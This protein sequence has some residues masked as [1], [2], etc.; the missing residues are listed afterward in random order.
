MRI[1]APIHT[2][3]TASSSE[4]QSRPYP[5]LEVGQKAPGFVLPDADM[6]I[7]NLIEQASQK[8]VVLHFY[9]R[10]RSPSGILQATDFSEHAAEFDALGCEAVAITPDD[11]PTHA[12]FRDEYGLSLRLLSDEDCDICRLYGAWGVRQNGE[13]VRAGVMR[14]T[15]I[16]DKRGIIREI[17]RNV[18]PRGHV[19]EVLRILQE[20]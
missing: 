15:F 12:E 10:D 6:D 8:H 13:S 4:A 19:A 7:F 9:P 17:F 1:A 3:H 14:S 5:V 20:L 2:T 16:I 11:C 18:V